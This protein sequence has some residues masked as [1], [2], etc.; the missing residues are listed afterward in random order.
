MST[1][2]ES[3]FSGLVVA[4]FEARLATAMADLIRKHGGTPLAAPALREIPI[5]DNSEIF[6]F[7]DHLIAGDFD[8][9]IFETGVGVRYLTQAIE[10]RIPRDA[11]LAALSRAKIV[12]RGPKPVAAL[13]GAEGSD[14]SSGSRAQ[15]L[16]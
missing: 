16:A 2:A 11:W 8:V 6:N 13:A 12:A 10:T 4:T 1:A 14:R 5:D 9:V 15:H 7:A 3:P